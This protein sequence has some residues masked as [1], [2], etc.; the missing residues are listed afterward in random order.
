M[1]T[2][3]F[4]NILRLKKRFANVAAIDSIYF[5]SNFFPTRQTKEI[6]KTSNDIIAG[7]GGDRYLK[8]VILV[9][10]LVD[11]L[12]ASFWGLFKPN[13]CGHFRKLFLFTEFNF[14]KFRKKVFLN[15][16]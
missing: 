11:Y 4:G 9:A 2:D 8:S 13:F 16:T 12:K 6:Y 10:R 7:N 5:F 1:K 3:F 14:S 15:C